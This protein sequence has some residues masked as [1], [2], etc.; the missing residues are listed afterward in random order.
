VAN[1]FNSLECKGNYSATS[2]NMKL[3]HWPLMGGCYIW[4]R[5]ERT[6]QAPPRCTKCS[7]PPIT[8]LLYNGPLLCGFNVPIQGLK[9]KYVLRTGCFQLLHVSNDV[10]SLFCCVRWQC[11]TWCHLSSCSWT[12]IRWLPRQICHHS[13]DSFVVQHPLDEKW[14]KNLTTKTRIVSWVK[15]CRRYLSAIQRLW[16]VHDYGAL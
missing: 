8:V 4:Y 11:H 13:T 14:S 12:N 10:K 9:I 6:G 2:N 16:F 7:I 15:V 3:V 1:C 5:E